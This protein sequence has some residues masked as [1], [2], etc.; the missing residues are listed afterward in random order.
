[1]SDEIKILL[2]EAREF[3]KQNEHLEAMKKCKKI[4][5]KDK[6]NYMALVL[7]ARAMQEVEEFKSQVVLVLQKAVEIQPNNP[8]AWQG[9]V[10]YYEK[11]SQD[12]DNWGKLATA[13]CKLLKLD[14]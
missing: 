10:A 5:K 6:N 8:L 1:M 11:A 2:K 14:R 12:D 4:L 9:L 7:L 3:F 13:Y